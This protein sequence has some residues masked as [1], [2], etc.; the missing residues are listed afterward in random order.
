MANIDEVKQGEVEQKLE[1]AVAQEA[2]IKEVF[3]FLDEMGANAIHEKLHEWNLI[4]DADYFHNVYQIEEAFRQIIDSEL[5]TKFSLLNPDVR[6]IVWR[7]LLEESIR[8]RVNLFVD[9]SKIMEAYRR[10]MGL[11]SSSEDINETLL[12]LRTENDYQIIT[13]KLAQIVVYIR[14][15][16]GD[17]RSAKT[18]VGDKVVA[19]IEPNIIKFLNHY[20]GQN[21]EEVYRWLRELIGIIPKPDIFGVDIAELRDT[22]EAYQEDSRK[23]NDPFRGVAEE[24]RTRV[25]RRLSRTV[26]DCINELIGFLHSNVETTMIAGCYCSATRE[27]KDTE[28]QS[29]LYKYLVEIRKQ[30]QL[31]WNNPFAA[32]VDSIEQQEFITNA[33]NLIGKLTGHNIDALNTFENGPVFLEHLN[34]DIESLKQQNSKAMHLGSTR[35]H[36]KHLII[37]LMGKNTGSNGQIIFNLITLDSILENLS[38]IYYANIVNMELAEINDCNYERALNVLVDLTLCARA[39]GQGTKTL[40][41]FSLLLKRYLQEGEAVAK[42]LKIH[43]VIAEMNDELSNYT[44]QLRK[45]LISLLPDSHRNIERVDM[46]ILNNMV[47][48]KTTHLL[49]NLLDAMRTYLGGTDSETIELLSRAQ[50]RAREADTGREFQLKD[51]VFQFGPDIETELQTAKNA[52]FMGGKGASLAEVSR[53]INTGELKDVDVPK[54]FG[55]STLTWPIAKDDLGKKRELNRLALT[56]LRELEIRTGK[57]FGDPENPLLLAARSGS[58]VSMPGILSTIAHIGLNEKIVKVWAQTLPGPERAYHAYIRFLFDYAKSVL[59]IKAELIL[60][61]FDVTHIADL[62]VKDLT[63]LKSTFAKIKTAV[64][65]ISPASNIPDDC[66]KQMYDS[67]E[68]VFHSYEKDDAQR[69]VKSKNIPQKYQ[70]ACVVQE[71]LPMLRENDCSGVFFTRDPRAGVKHQIEFINQSGEDLVGGRSRPKSKT[72]FKENYP[73]QNKI[74]KETAAVLEKRYTHPNDIEFLIRNGKI[75]IVQTRKLV[76][77]PIATVVV[78]YRFFEKGIITT[79]ELLG[80]TGKIVK[81]PLVGTF[82]EQKDKNSN[83]LIAR[84]EPISGGA[85]SGRLVCDESRLENYSQEESIIFLTKSNLPRNVTDQSQIRGYI[86]EEGGVTSHAALMSVGKLPI[87]EAQENNPDFAKAKS[88]IL[89]MMVV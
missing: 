65:E 78:Y 24:I 32:S 46:R 72:E 8:N 1:M 60:Q 14:R 29:D 6:K 4:D 71:C 22:S 56:Q 39:T 51:T 53:L 26:V 52:W 16:K 18:T 30:L 76:L 34:Q 3:P 64:R 49:G 25:H 40:G 47:R 50:M 86:S 17:L 77:A 9:D 41:R 23:D 28:I 87:Y 43:F 59:G 79:E 61:K 83:L 85:V 69:H 37:E 12:S 66:Y 84:G 75:Y 44:L 15:E 20:K 73:D 11:P 27:Q 70:T 42:K 89:Q 67:I 57:K 2:T 74:L 82:L 81:R 7:I 80:R 48:E 10:A 63:V 31:I 13:F 33:I 88:K 54:G 21:F 62:C 5:S 36:L 38:L 19:E 58:I 68:A 35:Y 45:T 55:L